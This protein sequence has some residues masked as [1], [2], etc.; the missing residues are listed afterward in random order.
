MNIIMLPNLYRAMLAGLLILAAGMPAASA[1][2]P[3]AA[4][5]R[6]APVVSRLDKAALLGLAA[7]GTRLVAVGER[8]LVAYSDDDGRTWAQ[9]RTPVSVT[10]TRVFFVSSST[11]WA[12]GHGGVILRTDDAGTTWVK[13]LDGVQAARLAAA[14]YVENA[15]DPALRSLAPAASQ[16]QSEG[17]DKPF[18]DIVFIDADRGLAVGAYGLAFRTKDGGRRWEPALESLEN[19]RGLHLYAL[20]RIGTAVI[21]AGEQGLLLKSTDGGRRF[22]PIPAPY[23]GSYFGALAL[24]GGDLYVF[25]LRGNAFR[26]TDQ[27]RSWTRVETPSTASLNSATTLSGTSAVFT[28]QEGQVL[29]GT[30][31]ATSLRVAPGIAPAAYTAIA[32]TAAGAWLLASLRGPVRIDATRLSGAATL[33]EHATK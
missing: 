25:G 28:N 14:K 3:Q 12:V 23:K 8:G 21:I 32:R 1:S 10:L 13:Q 18:F 24:E 22:E 30:S 26:S 15:Q 33:P 31:S 4:W 6:P 2:P 16:L 20:A 19:A 17:A 9:A 11:G 29:I 7:A 5:E 27:G